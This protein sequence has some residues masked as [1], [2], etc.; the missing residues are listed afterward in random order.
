MHNRVLR[1][2]QVHPLL[3]AHLEIFDDRCPKLRF[4]RDSTKKEP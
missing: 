1:L 3:E 4:T 2:R